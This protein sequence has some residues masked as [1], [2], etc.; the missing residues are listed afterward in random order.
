MVTNFTLNE[1]TRRAMIDAALEAQRKAYTP[2][3][4]FPVGAAILTASGK[5]FTGCNV[6]IA[7]Y[8]ATICAERTA[9]V[10]AISEGER[11]LRAVV[12]T[13]SNGVTPC[14]ICRQTLYEFGP[15]MLVIAA[16]IDGQVL[17]EGSL[18]DLLPHGFG[19][20]KLV[21]G[22]EAASA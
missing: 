7:S 20:Q 12:V 21:E 17:W 2:Y 14:G 8:G 9:V 5:V 19:P 6:E 15:D 4:D 16:D 22:Q 1:E 10:K 13:S 3:S 18:S 11:D